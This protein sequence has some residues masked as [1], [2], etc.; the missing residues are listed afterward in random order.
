M[1]RCLRPSR[2]RSTR[3]RRTSR[4]TG[5]ES[6]R[7]D[8]G[9]DIEVDGIIREAAA[10]SFDRFHLVGYSAGGASSLAF[11]ARYGERLLSLALLEPALAGNVRTQEEKR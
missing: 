2:I 5:A 3:P 9:L 11:A 10:R 1:R 6:R 7:P 4:C 8:Y